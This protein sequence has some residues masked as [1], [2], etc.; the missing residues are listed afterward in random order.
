MGEIYNI[1][2]K[3]MVSAFFLTIYDN[4]LTN[5]LSYNTLQAEAMWYLDNIT[6]LPTNFQDL[7]TIVLK[8]NNIIES[9]EY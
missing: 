1:E 5:F 9:M 7:K 8:V 4:E 6:L 2:T 3:L